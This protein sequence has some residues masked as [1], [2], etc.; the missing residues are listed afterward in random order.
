MKIFFALLFILNTSLV[1]AAGLDGQWRGWGT[2]TYEGSGTPCNMDLS[3]SITKDSFARKSGY[4]DCTVVG[5]DLTP[6]T[7]VKKGEDLYDGDE[8]VGKLTDTSLELTEYYDEDVTVKTTIQVDGHHFDYREVWT[9]SD[10][11]QIYLITGRMFLR[12]GFSGQ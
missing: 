3:F 8:L 7:F 5:L 6:A 4:F 12:N 2:W 1:M 11:G 10:G 9:G